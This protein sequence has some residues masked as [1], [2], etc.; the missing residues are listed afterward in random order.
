MLAINILERAP[1]AAEEC[2][3][4]FQTC[5]I[6]G[7]RAIFFETYTHGLWVLL[8]CYLMSFLPLP[9][10]GTNTITVLLMQMLVITCNY[11]FPYRIL[12]KDSGQVK[13]D[14]RD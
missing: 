6:T 2:D 12:S 13:G 4:V 1:A 11:Y 14:P 7:P 5:Q 9:D 8:A 3:N 10:T